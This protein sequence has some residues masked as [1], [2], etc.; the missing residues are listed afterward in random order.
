MRTT[1]VEAALS[2]I[3]SAGL[4]GATVRRIAEQAGA[5]TGLVTH[6]F[7]NKDEILIAALRHVHRAAGSRMLDA[8]IG[9]QGLPALLAVIEESLPL[10]EVRRTEWKIWLAFWGHATNVP[11]L[12]AE[13]RTRYEEWTNLL[14]ELIGNAGLETSVV[15]LVAIIDGVGVQATVNP[16]GMPPALQLA[17]VNSYLQPAS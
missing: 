3:A 17:T 2:V 16:A 5:T 4:E 8:S 1:I 7:A 12:L 11:M 9:R 14:T 10:D 15:G 6:Y 13:Q